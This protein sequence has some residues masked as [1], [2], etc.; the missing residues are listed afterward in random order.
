ML[1]FYLGKFGTYKVE[2]TEEE[3]RVDLSLTFQPQSQ[4]IQTPSNSS[5]VQ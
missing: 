1:A 3:I 2:E 4:L 5:R